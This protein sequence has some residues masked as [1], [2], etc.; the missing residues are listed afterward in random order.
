[1]FEEAVDLS[2]S[3][4]QPTQL[5]EALS[6]LAMLEAMRG[7][8]QSC[9]AH[10]RELRELTPLVDVPFLMSASWHAEGMLHLALGDAAAAA[11]ALLPA[12]GV[13]AGVNWQAEAAADLVEALVLAG[14][15]DQA[16]VAA[17]QIPS[18]RAAALVAV[19]DDEAVELLAQAA[20]LARD[21]W[22]RARCRLLAGERLRRAGQRR[23]A[24]EHL[25]AA[26]ESFRRAG[27]TPWQ[28]RASDGLRSS[29]EVLSTGYADTTA[30]TGAELRVAS[31]VVEGR[32]TR[33]VA[34]L[35]FLSP[36]TVEFHLGRIYRKLGVRDRTGLARQLPDLLQAEV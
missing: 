36:K 4:E 23:Q 25:R 21:P 17:A 27:A 22:E 26:A 14:R 15:L 29:G 12:L 20:D 5:L 13:P 11:A 10:V 2:R 18:L 28:R 30:L 34:A 1:M 3:A 24:R 9:L 16:R 19:H 32:S 8:E 31:L 6:A 7:E 35:L 33:E